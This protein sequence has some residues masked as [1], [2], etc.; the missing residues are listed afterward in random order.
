VILSHT[1]TQTH[2]HTQTHTHTYTHTHTPTHTHAPTQEGEALCLAAAGGHTDVI[3]LLLQAGCTVDTQDGE[4]IV[5][6]ASHGQ[7]EVSMH[8]CCV[9][10]WFM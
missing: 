6:A 1:R 5:R 3:E 9:M 2:A 10:F 4:P 7:L 8:Y